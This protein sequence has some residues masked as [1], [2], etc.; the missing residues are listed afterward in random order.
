MT[1]GT[2]NP[3]NIVDLFAGCGG[4]TQGFHTFQPGAFRT[5]GAVEW[6]IAAASTYAANF[7]EEAGGTDHIYAGD[8][9]QWDPQAVS[10]SVDVILGGP[11]C[12]GFSGLGKE[13]PHDPRNKLWKEYVRVVRALQPRIFVIENVDR[14]MRS[15]EFELLTASTNEKDGDLRDYVLQTNLLNAADYGVPQTRRRVIVLATHRDLVSSHPSG[16]PLKHPSPT[17]RKPDGKNDE[18]ALFSHSRYWVPSRTVFKET[19]LETR[20][21]E[22]PDRTCNLLGKTLPGTFLTTDLHIG[23]NPTK[24]SLKRYRAIPEGGNRH[25]LPEELSTPN[26]INHRNGSGDVMGRLWYDRPSVTIRTEFYKPEKGRYLHPE[27][28]RPIT[29]LEAALLQGF[30]LN[31]RWVGSKVQIAR[32]IGNAVPVGLA[33]VIAGDLY[34]YLRAAEPGFGAN[35]SV[36]DLSAVEFERLVRDLFLAM[37]AEGWA[38]IAAGD[39][40][41]DVLATSKDVSSGGV[42]L[43]QAMR[44]SGPVGL[45]SVHA[46]SHLMAEYAAESGVLITPSWFDRASEQFAQQNRITL[47]NGTELRHLVGRHLNVELSSHVATPPDDALNYGAGYA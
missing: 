9:A 39:G 21:T 1:T 40:R 24:H 36:I 20:T 28:D 2:T 19:G 33:K 32:Q 27:A 34:R 18:G 31:Y 41:A 15:R 42:R 26:W 46:L 25:N 23:R 44:W 38:D 6:D 4:L 5:V 37:G 14:F 16:E 12:Q 13:D 7:A 10:S 43:I 8:I 45:E 47:I 30:P 29:H 11:P 35:P 3:I 17:H 22:L